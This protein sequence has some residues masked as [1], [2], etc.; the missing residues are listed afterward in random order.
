MPGHREPVLRRRRHAPGCRAARGPVERQGHRL[1]D[2]RDRATRRAAAGGGALG[3]GLTAPESADLAACREVIRVHSRSFHAASKLLPSDVRDAAVATYAFCRGAD[4]DV[5]DAG[6][7]DAARTRH[8]R[9]RQR[10][11]RLYAGDAMDTPVGRAFAWVVRGRGIPRAEPEALLDGMAQDLERVVRVADE[12]ALLLYCYRAAGVVGR[13]MSRI[14]GRA[15]DAALRRA[16]DLGIAMQLTN[17]ARDVGEDAARDRVYLP[18]TWLAA[19]SSSFDEVLSRRAAP[20][21]RAATLRVLARAED[22]YASGIGG[23]AL[24]PRGCRPSILSAA[25]LYRAIGRRVRARGGDGVTA[26]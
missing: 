2:P 12:E 6:S 25:L 20:G 11:D 14:M 13:M 23:I 19:E 17:I 16:V 21:V 26:R 1:P 10:L 22:Y 24:L 7:P 4:D 9:T 5:D 18:G 15:D 8:A 3:G